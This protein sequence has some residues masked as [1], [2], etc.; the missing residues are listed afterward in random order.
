MWLDGIFVVLFRTR[1]VTCFMPIRRMRIMSFSRALSDCLTSWVYHVTE[2]LWMEGVWSWATHVQAIHS[3]RPILRST[4]L[5][6]QP[7]KK[8][9]T[10]EKSMFTRWRGW[11]FIPSYESIC[12]GIWRFPKFRA[13]FPGGFSL[14]PWQRPREWG[15][16]SHSW[17]TI[18]IPR[19]VPLL[20]VHEVVFSPSW[21]LI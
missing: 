3:Q 10:Y 19:V 21:V 11:L 4:K 18:S 7:P 15:K 6:R 12:V 2:A 1:Y 5:H 20:C 9:P 14:S 13:K 17:E 8:L 16:P